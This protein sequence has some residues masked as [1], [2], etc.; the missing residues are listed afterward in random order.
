MPSSQMHGLQYYI[1]K[2]LTS[3]TSESAESSISLLFHFGSLLQL[4]APLYTI[5]ILFDGITSRGLRQEAS[6][7]EHC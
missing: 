3:M 2:Y 7:T 1:L 5:L 6:N 4:H